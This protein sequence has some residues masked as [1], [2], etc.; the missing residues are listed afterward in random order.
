MY[1]P[2]DLPE[3]TNITPNV[4]EQAVFL[5]W[6]RRDLAGDE[7]GYDEGVDGNDTGHNHRNQRLASGIQYLNS[8]ILL[9]M[10]TPS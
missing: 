8:L 5:P 6:W 7:D 1:D 9:T 4:R 2:G 10:S 3:R